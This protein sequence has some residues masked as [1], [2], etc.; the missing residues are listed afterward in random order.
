MHLSPFNSSRSSTRSAFTNIALFVITVAPLQGQ[1][2]TGKP[3]GSA[4]TAAQPEDSAAMDQESQA[5]LL[6][7]KLANP[8]ANLISV[9]FQSNWDFNIGPAHATR[10]TLNFQP[11]IPI[12]INKDWNVVIRTIVPFIDAESPFKGGD[13]KTGLSDTLQS[14]FFSPKK[15]TSKGWIW[16]AGPVFLWRTATDDALGTEKFGAG[17]TAVVLKQQNG[18]TYGILANQVWSIAG[19]EDR[20]YVN[21]TYLLPF[22]SF[23]TK[24]HT[25]IQLNTESTYNWH[26]DQWTVPLNLNVSQLLKVGKQVISVGV[27]GRYY[28]EAPEGGP[29]WGLRCTVTFLFPK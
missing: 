10:Y 7:K 21:A 6:A 15:P 20:R 8:T 18:W 2:A 19:Q 9:P 16:G 27:G 14:F 23:T 17:P 11:V 29:D 24:T 1:T 28:A 5:T 12:S 26:D 13:D 3:T 4:L 22:L 25:T